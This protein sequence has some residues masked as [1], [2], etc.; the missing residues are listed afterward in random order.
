[1]GGVGV[2]VQRKIL[3]PVQAW[4]QHLTKTADQRKILIPVSLCVCVC[5]CV[6]W[7]VKKLKI[8]AGI[9]RAEG[10]DDTE[11]LEANLVSRLIEIRASDTVEEEASLDN[12]EVNDVKVGAGRLKGCEACEN[13]AATVTIMRCHMRKIHEWGYEFCELE[14]SLLCRK[15]RGFFCDH[16]GIP[17]KREGLKEWHTGSV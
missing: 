3:I 13:R 4:E 1:M 14:V 12:F 11:E 17:A 15:F 16:C 8:E 2:G 5:V 6:W 7:E 10:H 9:D